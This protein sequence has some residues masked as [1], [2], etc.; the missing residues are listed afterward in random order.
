MNY[1]DLRGRRATSDD[2]PALQDMWRRTGIASADLEPRFTEF[3]VIEDPL[4]GLVAAVGIR[5]LGKDAMMHTETI[6]DFGSADAVRPVMWDRVQALANNNGIVR[7]WTQETA[8]F[9]RQLEFSTATAEDLA[10]LPAPFRTGEGP[11]LLR[12]LRD[13]DLIKR[14]EQEL[15]MFHQEEKAR[16][17]GMKS[18]GKVW[19]WIATAIAITLFVFVVVGAVRL[20]KSTQ[21][22]S[23]LKE[24]AAC[25]V[26]GTTALPESSAQIR[27]SSA[28]M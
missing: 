6:P 10:K 24:P 8:A 2:V 4:G 23:G 7:V 21:R 19:Q 25:R 18:Q 3:Q 20:L 1:E 5:L 12:V 9:W 17:D 22:R 11:W 28:S 26:G 15:A 13:E 14:A 16:I 27:F